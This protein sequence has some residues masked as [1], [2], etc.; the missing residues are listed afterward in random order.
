MENEKLQNL[1]NIKEVFSSS[2]E[3][4]DSVKSLKSNLEKVLKK[5]EEK[6]IRLS[7]R[8]TAEL[9]ATENKEEIANSVAAEVEHKNTKKAVETNFESAIENEAKDAVKEIKKET[10]TKTE[11][12][13]PEGKVAKVTDVKKKDEVVEQ[14]IINS[15]TEEVLFEKEIKPQNTQVKEPV[16]E[17]A[18]V[19]K[20]VSQTKEN[21]FVP[22]KNFNKP[23]KNIQDNSQRNKDYSQRQSYSK[24]DFTKSNYQQ[25]E[26]YQKQPYQ[27][28]ANSQRFADRKPYDAN[29]KRNF[30]TNYQKKP[31]DAN[32]PKKPYDQNAQK[33]SYQDRAQN[34]QRTQT[35]R[36]LI[37]PDLTF[38]A[39]DTKPTKKD[40]SAA[41]KKTNEKNYESNSKAMNKRALIRKGFVTIDNTDVD[42]KM[43][44][45]KFKV[46]K[47]KTEVKEA[48]PRID[49]AIITTETIT[50]KS[51]SEK[52]GRTTSEILQKMVLL[53]YM[54]NINS[55]I[56]FETAQL[57]ALDLGVELEQKL[58]KTSEEV[59]M[60]IDNGEDDEKDL[61]TRPPV[62]TVMGHVDHGK[63]SILDYYRKTKVTE[64][65]A[66]G[67]TQHIGAY[68]I[69]LKGKQITFI[70]TP[71]HAAFT[72]M[73]ARGAK[74]TDIVILVV[75]ADDGVMPQTIEAINHAKSANV[76]II[77]AVNKIDKPT[78]DIER[79]KQ[80]LTE[81]GIVPEE[82][83]GDA[84]I[85]PCSAKTG[86]GMLD[87]LDMIL[88]VAEMRDLKANPNR[89]AKGAIIEAKLD[90]GKGPVATVLVQ[91][92]TL[93]VGDVV[94]SGTTTGKIRAMVDDTGRPVKSAG[95]SMPVSVIGFNDV[96]QAGDIV[97]VTSEEKLS[98]QVA[99]ERRN[100]EKAEKAKLSEKITLDD[101]YQKIEQG[102]LK[103]LRIIVKADV[104]GSA[105]A[106]KS[107]LEKIKNEECRVKVVH[108]GVGAISESDVDLANVTNAIII[109]FNVRPSAN[110]KAAAEKEGI[111][112]RLYNIIYNAI[113]DVENALKGML[114]VKYKETVLGHAEVRNVFKISNVGTIAGSYVTDGKILRQAKVKIYR[115]NVFIY[116]GKISS[117]K[118]LK[119]DAKEI[120]AGFE[121]GIG[122]ENYNDIK[123]GDLLE[124][125]IME[126]V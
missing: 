87:M 46:K 81:N 84:I 48:A 76:P 86:E 55:P 25:K 45:K 15:V 114:S 71:G 7:E 80:Q 38:V 41:K 68:T 73:R 66:G 99:E 9:S 43:G 83:G 91:N 33:R 108:S 47:A 29:S 54:V 42:E 21:T 113:E 32:S 77:V 110:A 13:K 115:D 93:R 97:Y 56:D 8:T 10:E 12:I 36:P 111:D 116:D 124:A 57:V 125:Y 82:W 14:N 50:V 23:Q 79:I 62:V 75:A 20:K 44:S 102:A 40:F 64:G 122:I 106:V 3:L 28:N 121:C 31:Y 104:Q 34:G 98:K 94:L 74:I 69:K 26:G 95:P 61:V 92:G 78:A 19:V 109:G 35:Q 67:I 1:M 6:E 39:A 126:T 22:D 85:A 65:E 70:D 100:R 51:L 52:I 107:S 90:K 18:E 101:M 5:V 63:T 37:K 96:P 103:E 119:D 120:S 4:L 27:P 117:L 49:K 89:L 72:A 58:E 60:D 59:L 123:I 30:D 16:E 88:L 105:E 24:S 118:H 53:G 17:K 11:D 112:I 2:A